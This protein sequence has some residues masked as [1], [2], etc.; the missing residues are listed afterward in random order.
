MLGAVPLLEEDSDGNDSIGKDGDHSDANRSKTSRPK[1]D[2][3][4]ILAPVDVEILGDRP[5]RSDT[6][7]KPS[8][9]LTPIDDSL[10]ESAHSGA[11]DKTDE[12]TEGLVG[13]DHVASLLEQ[14]GAD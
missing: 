1:R 4:S 11:L 3:M 10:H 6:G 8:F 7:K 14:E 13:F 12:V 5:W 9:T 2:S